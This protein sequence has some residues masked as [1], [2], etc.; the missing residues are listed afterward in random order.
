[1]SKETKS[2]YNLIDDDGDEMEVT[3]IKRS[4]GCN[5][6]GCVDDEIQIDDGFFIE[7]ITVSGDITPIIEGLITGDIKRACT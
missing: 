1:M 5:Q 6:S 2:I 7:C 3:I 4:C